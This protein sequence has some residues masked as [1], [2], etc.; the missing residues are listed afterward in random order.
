MLF[1]VVAS[2][3][4]PSQRLSYSSGEAATEVEPEL[5]DY[6]LQV[7]R[8]I[9]PSGSQTSSCRLGRVELTQKKTTHWWLRFKLMKRR[10]VQSDA[11]SFPP[12]SSLS[13][14]LQSNLLSMTSS[15][16]FLSTSGLGTWQTSLVILEGAI[17]GIVL[18]VIF[19]AVISLLTW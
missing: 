3:Y 9:F 15:S 13:Y 7:L 2:H 10:P 1:L 4:L 8:E 18:P 5:G 11:P 17:L 19:L 14:S 12:F 6:S 16:S